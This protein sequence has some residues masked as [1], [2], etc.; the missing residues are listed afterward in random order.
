MTAPAA[1]WLW[2]WADFTRFGRVAALL[3]CHNLILRRSNPI[4]TLGD[5]TQGASNKR[6][7]NV[8]N[9]ARKYRDSG[10]C[11]PPPAAPGPAAGAGQERPAQTHQSRAAGRGRPR[12]LHLGRPRPVA[13][14]RPSRD[15]GYFRRFGGSGQRGHAGRRARSRR[16]RRGAPAAG[17][18]LARGERRWPPD[19]PAARG[20]RA[21]V[22]V[23]PARGPLVRRHVAHVVAV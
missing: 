17:R 14:R 19:R 11:P 8:S 18:F 22:P 13:G 5:P 12:R 21:P 2:T 6:C 23:R 20:G 4:P 3:H 7:V 1:I 15:R 9:L 16:S 10:A